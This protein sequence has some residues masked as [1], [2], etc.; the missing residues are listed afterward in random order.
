MTRSVGPRID[1][2][3]HLW[4]L[5]TGGYAWLTPAAGPLYSTFTAHEAQAE[6]ETAGMSAAILVQAEDSASDTQSMLAVADAHRWVAGV[7]GWV[8]LDEPEQTTGMLDRWMLHPTFCGVRHLVHDD[9]RENFLELPAV[10]ESLRQVAA[11]GLA[12]DVPDAWPRILLQ[13]IELAEKIPELT[14]AID[15]LGKPPIVHVGDEETMQR[16]ARLDPEFQAWR[17]LFERAARLPNVVAKVSGLQSSG[18][19]FSVAAVRPAW[20][21]ALDAFGPARLMYGGDWPMTVAAGGY[22]QAWSV[23]SA[24]IGELNRDE[25]SQLLFSTAKQAYRVPDRHH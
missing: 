5:D 23:Y 25:Q 21:V 14:V 10:H 13:A 18:S 19:P 8:P 17:E 2:H 1:A 3:L 16:D 22:Q 12:F 24:L 11:R 6:L 7:V 20:E 4:D 15:H 9:P